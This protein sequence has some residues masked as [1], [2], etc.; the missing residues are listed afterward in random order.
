MTE[1]DVVYTFQTEDDEYLHM[2]D[3]RVDAQRG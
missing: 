1:K 3:E 2:L